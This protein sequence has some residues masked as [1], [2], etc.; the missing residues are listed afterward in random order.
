MWKLKEIA[1]GHGK[2]ENARII[3]T[4]L[5]LLKDE[6]SEIIDIE[7]GI[8]VV[9][10]AQAYDVVLYSTFKNKEDLNRYQI[11]PSHVKVAGFIGKVRESRVV[12]DYEI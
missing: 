11:N 4:E 12:V 5:E 8:N 1:E 9:E 6:I 2:L 10:D 3:K 7:V